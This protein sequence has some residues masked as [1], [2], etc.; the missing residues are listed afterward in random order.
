MQALQSS[1]CHPFCPSWKSIQGET[2][3]TS[4][5]STVTSVQEI[6]IEC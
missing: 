2:R 3:Q 4:E 6:Q 5:K 1:K